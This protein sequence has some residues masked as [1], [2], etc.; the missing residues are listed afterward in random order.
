MSDREATFG[1]AEGAPNRDAHRF[2][3][4][5]MATVFEV[6]C[7]HEDGRYARQ[8]ADAAFALVDRL[9]Q[10]LSRF[11]ANSDVSRVNALTAGQSTGVSATTLECLAIARHLYDVTSRTFDV[12]VGTGLESLELDP[13]THTIHARQGG[14]RLDLGG[15]GKGYAID[16]MAELLGEWEV[17]ESLVHGGFSSVL[18]LEPPPGREGWLLSLS[19]PGGGDILARVRARRRAFSASGTRKG[20]HIQDPRTGRVVANRA[21]WVSIS[22]GAPAGGS[23]A[24]VAEGLSTAFMILGEEQIRDLCKDGP[25]LEAWLLLEP[26]AGAEA[27]SVLHLTGSNGDRL[28]S[29]GSGRKG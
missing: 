23:P 14:V 2:S 28:E 16:R 11:V 6:L 25:G 26:A 15:I 22:G 1:L 5:A 27:A 20:R 7:I 9:E 18:A 3:H 8:A 29:E 4:E 13:D 10:Q 17:H 21:V 24:A 12:S 19:A